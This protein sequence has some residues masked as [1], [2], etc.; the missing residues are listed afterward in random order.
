VT[1]L[2]LVTGAGGFAGRHLVEHLRARGDEVIT[3][4]S[5]ELDL[6]DAERTREF[7]AGA[8]PGFIYHLAALASVDRSWHDQGRTLVENQSMTLNV[9]EAVSKEAP[10][11]RVLLAGSGEIYGPPRELPVDEEA[12]LAPRNPYAVSKASADLLGAMYANAH[13]L[14]VVRT[15]AFNHAGPGQSD[16]YACGTFTRQV[17]EAEAAG[18]AEV[19]LRTGNLDSARDFTDVRDVVAAYALAIGLEPNAYNVASGRATPVREL[20]ELVRAATDIEV[21]HE[22]DPARVREFDVPEVRGSA[23]RLRAA[24]G[25][26]PRISLE[27][28]VEDA[29][30]AW[31][32]ELAGTLAT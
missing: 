3:P 6:R 32:R 28:T 18:S 8:Q 23:E 14:S 16:T 10:G 26:E 17:A 5:A 9:L 13:G 1:G 11:A 15:R 31:R 7:V 27:R 2:A 21:R 22:V 24:T 19:V 4:T 25:W 12:P 20:I 29:L 30:A